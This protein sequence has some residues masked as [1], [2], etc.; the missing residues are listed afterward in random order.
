MLVGGL[1]FI[2]YWLPYFKA[3]IS[4]IIPI[5]IKIDDLLLSAVLGGVLW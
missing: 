5:D 4:Y 3:S 1:S 2:V